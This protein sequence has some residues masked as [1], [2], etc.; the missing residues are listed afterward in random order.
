MEQILQILKANQGEYISGERLAKL[1]GITRAAIW[2][3]I[4]QLREIGYLIESTPRR[5]YKLL[6]LTGALHPYEIKEGLQTAVFGHN[7]D[8]H[9]EID[10]TN[11]R[12]RK[13]AAQGAPEGT[14]V[15]AE[16]QTTGRGRLGRNWS[17]QS[18]LGL[19]F[20]LILRPRVSASEL[21]VVTILTAVSLTR[22]IQ[23]ATGIQVQ[24]KW[25]NDLLYQGSKLAGI[26]AELNGE[27]DRVNY[28][29]LGIGLNVN[30]ETV[31]FPVE[32]QDKAISLRLINNMI[33]DRKSILQ[34]FLRKFEQS[35][36]MLGSGRMDE[37]IEY[38]RKHSA[39]LDKQVVINQ[40]FGKTLTG[41]ALDLDWDGSL[42]LEDQTGQKIKVYSG[43]IIETSG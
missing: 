15:I 24:V 36:T 27:M 12:A 23:Q 39:T 34:Q 29:I 31:D 35:Y 4:N 7:I 33:F 6:N 30:H 22:A 13:L 25:P 32:L 3:Q 42:W 28:L 17:S 26:L 40:G 8:Y 2:K 38:A 14:V 43:E 21:A 19:W 10:S 9:E 37:V 16:R 18:G 11:L 1:S 41:T 5:G 20:S